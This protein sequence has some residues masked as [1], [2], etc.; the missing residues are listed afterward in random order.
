[1]KNVLS[2]F[3]ML[4]ILILIC[5]AAWYFYTT[6]FLAEPFSEPLNAHK[7]I[8]G[9]LAAEKQK[10]IWE[11]EQAAIQIEHYVGKEFIGSLVE[12][13]P[14]RMTA[15]FGSDFSTFIPTDSKWVTVTRPPFEESIRVTGDQEG[16]SETDA[17]F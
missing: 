6:N 10:E 9:M 2:T 17:V 12:A 13:D 15:M 8:P 5:V 14:Q 7:E 16:L 1:M 3:A 11:Q 4:A